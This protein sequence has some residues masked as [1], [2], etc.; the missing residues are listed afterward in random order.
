MSS[1]YRSPFSRFRVAGYFLCFLTIRF[2]DFPCCI[3]VSCMLV[4]FPC[5]VLLRMSLWIYKIFFLHKLYADNRLLD[6]LFLAVS[7]LSPLYGLGLW[8]FF[9]DVGRSECLCFAFLTM[10]FQRLVVCSFLW[11]FYMDRW[12]HR[13]R[14]LY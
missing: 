13:F 7:F 11:M 8:W 4:F 12:A 10:L 9:T 2:Q 1:H 5:F 14:E 3:C 6:R